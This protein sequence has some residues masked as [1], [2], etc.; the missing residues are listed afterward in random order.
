MVIDV[1]TV[2]TNLT[3]AHNISEWGCVKFDGVLFC[4]GAGKCA[5][6]GCVAGEICSSRGVLVSIPSCVRVV[7]G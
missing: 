3:W 6:A 7:D 5:G 2:A 4:W 1:M